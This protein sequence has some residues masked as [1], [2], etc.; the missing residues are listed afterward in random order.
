[1]KVLH[2][3]SSNRYSGAENVVC[4][5]INLFENKNDK[6][7][8]VYCSPAGEIKDILRNKNIKYLELKNF[9]LKELKKIVKEYNPDI[10]H[11]HDIKASV[12]ASIVNRKIPIVSHIHGKFR[13]MSSLSFKSIIYRIALYRITHVCVV[14]KSIL[15]EYYFKNKLEKKCSILYNVVN[16]EEI[17]KKIEED[18]Q[19]YLFDGVYLG[20]FVY[21]K[22]PERLIRILSKVIEYNPKA[23]FALIGD[24]ELLEQ[25]KELTIKLNVNKNIE[26]MGFK[27]NPYKIL[28]QAKVMI[29][30]SRTEGT[31]MC[32]LEA[33]SIGIPIVSTPVDGVKELI[34]NGQDGIYSDDDKDLIDAIT[35]LILDEEYQRK[36]SENIINKGDNLNNIENYKKELNK[37]YRT[38]K[39]NFKG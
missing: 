23:K 25:T 3:L 14:S 33:M 27:N 37:I 34:E 5:I 24:G 12:I 6:V 22:N 11:A 31:P 9:S 2:I 18:R 8:M 16:K 13:E 36:I 1:M 38:V 7:E 35:R 29:M 26:F 21:A 30:T 10:I 32:I 4:Q 15:E 20:R 17:S 19:E 39:R 28:S